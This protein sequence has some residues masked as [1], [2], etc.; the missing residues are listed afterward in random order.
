MFVH[1]SLPAG[2]MIVSLFARIH[3]RDWI[4]YCIAFTLLL[5]V[6]EL[7]HV[8]AAAFFR[9]KVMAVEISGAGG[10]CHVE[11]PSRLSQFIVVYS[12]GL[13][14]QAAA[15][16]IAFTYL[17]RF[18]FP[19]NKFAVACLFMFVVVNL[20]VFV[21]NLIP[22]RNKRSGLGTDGW[23]L[24]KLFL[25][26]FR[27]H[28]HPFPPLV[29]A[30]PDQAPVFPPETRL[31]DKPGFRPAGFVHGIE[32]LND[33]T[34]PMEFVISV[35]TTH[36]G[37]NREQAIVKMLEIHNNGGAIIALPSQTRARAV[38]DAISEDARS[39]GHS[40]VCRYAG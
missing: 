2:G 8:A 10:L 39:S 3:P 6:H 12:A 1:W 18:G 23:V 14:A 7:G 24:W 13:L 33:R 34:T 19:Q 28:P 30:P 27:G 37:L 17:R 40:F 25:H 26:V 11:R 9:L 32:I 20:I 15:F 21:I 5:I 35:L 29:V 31:L 16:A 36:L 22:Q 38:A 4:Y